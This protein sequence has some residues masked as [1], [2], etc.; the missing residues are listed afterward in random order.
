MSADHVRRAIA[1][2][3]DGPPTPAWQA[4][5]LSNLQSSDSLSV[6]EVRTLGAQQPGPVHRLHASIDRRLLYPGADALAPVA[7]EQLPEQRSTGAAPATLTVWLSQRPL[8]PADDGREILYLR[9]DRRAEPADHAFRRAVLG[10]EGTVETEALLRRS[11]GSVVVERSVSGVR[12]FSVTLGRD[13]ALWKFAELVRRAA[14]R[15][16]GSGS[17]ASPPASP[18]RVSPLAA[19]VARS[20]VV[21]PRVLAN[22]AL[23]RRP[24]SVRVRVRAAEPTEGWSQRGVA[25]RWADGHMYADPFLFEH[26]GRHH[27]FCEDVGG[28][29]RG[30]ISHSELR[31]DGVPAGQPRCVLAESYHLSYPFV[32]AHDGET[33]MIPETSA[34]KRVEL[35]RATDFPRSWEREAILLD[36]ID[37]ADATLLQ[38]DGRL[39]LFVAVAPAHASSLDELHLF[40]ASELRGPWLAHPGN[41]VVSNA[42]RARPAGAIQTWG[43]RLIR[44]GQ[45]GSRRYG[46]AIAFCEIDVLS[47]SDYAEHEIARLEPAEVRGA[48]ATHTYNSDLAF[49]AIDL[50]RRELRLARMLRRRAA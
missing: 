34:V 50:R 12:A 24:W 36:G 20:L 4:R 33:F 37:A 31:A 38:H 40:S 10:G 11:A 9:H 17:P 42:R 19:A 29:G 26:E 45:D 6:V 41:P 7:L 16:P 23:Y 1:V 32:F 46:G 14:E 28:D 15:A 30:V 21:W 5:A 39:W 27:L 2:V 49:E 8:P 44:P 35:Y 43:S 25:V 18:Q 22:R 47:E 48:R 3:L 13:Q